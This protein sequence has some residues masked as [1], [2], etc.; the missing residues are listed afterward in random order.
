MPELDNPLVTRSA[1]PPNN[2]YTL[3]VWIRRPAPDILAVSS[4]NTSAS[5]ENDGPLNPVYR[6]RIFS[7]GDFFV[8]RYPLDVYATLPNP[9]SSGDSPP[10]SGSGSKDKRASRST[11]PSPPQPTILATPQDVSDDKHVLI[12]KVSG[13]AIQY[14]ARITYH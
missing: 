12:A 3:R 11:K 9:S 7:Y 5:A 6:H 2:H 10:E 8:A 14:I 1:P 13:V 4:A